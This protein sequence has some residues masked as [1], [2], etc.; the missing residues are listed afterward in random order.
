MKHLFKVQQR[1]TNNQN[2]FSRK[3]KEHVHE[4][5]FTKTAYHPFSLRTQFCYLYSECTLKNKTI[6]F[7]NGVIDDSIFICSDLLQ[8]ISV[9]ICDINLRC[10]KKC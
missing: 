2:I 7:G 6:C 10:S 5:Q 4:N 9:C 1:S 3:L 8:I